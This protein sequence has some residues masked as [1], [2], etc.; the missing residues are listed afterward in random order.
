MCL[1]MRK[2]IKYVKR[3][4]NVLYQDSIHVPQI[5]SVMAL[6]NPW[7]M[8]SHGNIRGATFLTIIEFPNFKQSPIHH[9]L[10]LRLF[11]V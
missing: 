1:S 2:H 6:F 9:I 3:F 11:K 7:Y 5:T 8:K 10:E 4:S